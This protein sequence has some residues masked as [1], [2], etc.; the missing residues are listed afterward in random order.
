VCSKEASEQL[1]HGFISIF[2]VI[3]RLSS[4]DDKVKETKDNLDVLARSIAKMFKG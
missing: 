2:S 1:E 4:L 3:N